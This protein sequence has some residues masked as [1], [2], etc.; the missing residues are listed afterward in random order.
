MINIINDQQPL[1]IC[2]AADFNGDE[3]IRSN[4]ISIAITNI[5]Q[6]CP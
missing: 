2:P 4:E 3:I 5:N 6:G 1:S